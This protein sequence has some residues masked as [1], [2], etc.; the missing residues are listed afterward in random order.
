MLYNKYPDNIKRVMRFITIFSNCG[1][2]GYPV[3]ESIYGKTGLFYT[4]VFNIPFTVFFWTVGV[5]LFTDKKDLKSTV[6]M[7]I[8]P[9]IVATLIGLTLFLFSIEL[10]Y[11]IYKACDLVGS[12]TTPLSMLVIGSMLADIDIKDV[13]S[14]FAIY[15]ATIVRL[16][17]IP[18]AVYGMLRLFDV[19]GI[20]LGIPVITMAM[21]AAAG[22]SIFAQKY[23]ADFAFSSRCVFITTALSLITIPAFILLV[24]R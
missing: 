16:L 20:L 10:P 4:V 23:D 14:G 8:N 5:M 24:S 7:V 21:P 12:M 9:G 2:M 11:A 15:Y 6:K 22:T 18:L 3:I 19:Q 13:F 17:A 1:F